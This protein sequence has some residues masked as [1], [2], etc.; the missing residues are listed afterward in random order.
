[1]LV[2]LVFALLLERV[3]TSDKHDRESAC[4]KEP[5]SLC[6]F[7]AT[8]PARVPFKICTHDPEEDIY[9]SRTI[10]TGQNFDEH[11]SSTIYHVLS[12]RHPATPVYVDIGGNIGFFTLLAAS[13]GATTISFE[14][15]LA[16]YQLLSRS[17]ELNGY[18]NSKVFFAAL[19]DQVEVVD[20]YKWNDNFG[21]TF[22]ALKND[23]RVNMDG[24]SYQASGFTVQLDSMIDFAIDL[25]K[26]DCEGCETRAMLGARSLISSKKLKTIVVEVQTFVGSRQSRVEAFKLFDLA[27]YYVFNLQQQPVKYSPWTWEELY[28]VLNGESRVLELVITIEPTLFL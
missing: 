22:V 8:V 27:G 7:N 19:A 1:M 21:S 28:K 17:V 4:P 6:R 3:T 14:P 12:S 2:L 26:I 20:L 13:L 15:L 25:L 18:L 5:S 16:N 24:V 9:V 23:S 11:I 10:L